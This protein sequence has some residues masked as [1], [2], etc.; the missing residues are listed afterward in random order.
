[1]DELNAALGCS[2]MERIEEILDKR[3]KIAGMYN[4]S[5]FIGRCLDIRKGIFRLNFHEFLYIYKL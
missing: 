1:M 2:Q 3:A 5:H 4:C